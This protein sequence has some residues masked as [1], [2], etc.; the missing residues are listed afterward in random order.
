MGVA[1]VTSRFILRIAGIG[2]VALVASGPVA[3]QGDRP[4]TQPLTLD[5][6]IGFALKN[7]RDIESSSHSVAA[8]ADASR[9]NS[10]QP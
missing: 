8:T 6:A 2:L 9:P 3:A 1:T 7:N 4:S 5:E 10:S